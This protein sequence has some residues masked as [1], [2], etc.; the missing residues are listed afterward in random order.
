MGR[1]MNFPTVII[2][3][4]LCVNVLTYA[5][6]PTIRTIAGTGLEKLNTASSA[7]ETNIG[8]PFGVE[9]TPNGELYICEVSNH[10]VWKLNLENKTLSIVAGTGKKGHSPDG[11]LATESDL[12]EPYEV[13]VDTDGDIY[14]V[15]MQ[16]HIVRMID[17]TTGLLTTIAGNGKQGFSGDGGPATSAMLNR[18]HSIAISG[19]WLFIADIGN[20][21][22][23]RVNLKSKTID[24][25]A[26]TTKRELPVDNG[27]VIGNPVLGPRALFVK[28]R[29][30]WVALREGHSV[31]KINVDKPTWQHVAGTGKKGFSGDGGPAVEATLNGPKGIAVTGDTAYVVDTE[32]QSIRAIT[33]KNGIIGTIAGVGPTGRGF[34]GE[35]EP[36]RQSFLNRPHG[37]CVDSNGNVY[38]GDSENHRVRLLNSRR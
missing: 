23:R 28:D 35:S 16:N 9:A 12:N 19:D 8:N 17:K 22:I 24:T 14:F 32:N 25:F 13:R 6:E 7:L 18:P 3:F 4:T 34:R 1:R 38:I 15:E 29:I 11:R 27:R 30:L 5:S 36:A 10:R 20:H 2:A 33:L 26:G 31:W 21:R 37:V